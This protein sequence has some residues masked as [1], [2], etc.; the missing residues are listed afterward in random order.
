MADEESRSS[1][2]PVPQAIL[3]RFPQQWK[4]LLRLS[5][6]NRYFWQLCVDHKSALDAS[7]TLATQT[8]AA[9]QFRCIAVEIEEEI[10]LMLDERQ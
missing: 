5:L 3:D 6:C 2:L 1:G 10:G 8:E 4:K 9:R 7:V